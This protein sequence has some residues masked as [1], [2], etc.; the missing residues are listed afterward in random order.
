EAVGVIAAQSIGEPG[1]QLTLRTFHIGGTTSRIVSESSYS[2][3]LNEGE[4]GAVRYI[5][6]DAEVKENETVTVGRNGKIIVAFSGQRALMDG[7]VSIECE[8]LMVDRQGQTV[9]LSDGGILQIQG[10]KKESIQKLSIPFGVRLG[11]GVEDKASV[12]AGDLLFTRSPW[13]RP[14]IAQ[15]EGKVKFVDVQEL[16]DPDTLEGRKFGESPLIQVVSGNEVLEEHPLTP[17]AKVLVKDGAKVQPGDFLAELPL[18]VISQEEGKVRFLGI[19]EGRTIQQRLDP[20]TGNLTS[21]VTQVDEHNVPRIAIIGRKGEVVTTYHLPIGCEIRVKDGQD[22]FRGDI[23]AQSE[24]LRQIEILPVGANF[25]VADNEQIETKGGQRAVL[26]QWDPYQ[27]PI[28]A[29][30]SGKVKYHDIELGVTVRQ[31]RDSG[32]TDD[33][34][35]SVQLIV[36]EQKEDKQPS[37]EIIGKSEE[38]NLV[39]LPSGAHIVVRDNQ[40]IDRGD[41]LARI[42]RESFKSR[43]VTGGLPRVEEI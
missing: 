13:A 23:L 25:K 16:G 3:N 42:P 12:K 38:A 2:A 19:A 11:K 7:K 15:V 29:T 39:S 9:I 17:R 24:N 40:K 34:K 31:H 33:A 28:I 26:A 6:V 1:T 20:V 37:L 22:V 5:N 41:T 27:I 8:K 4:I 21:I 30:E 14:L 36:M 43:D 18:P 10:R 35:E 32:S